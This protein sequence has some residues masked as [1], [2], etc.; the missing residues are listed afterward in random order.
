V[1]CQQIIN[2]K[3]ITTTFWL[4]T[5]LWIYIL[6]T[7]THDMSVIIHFIFLFLIIK[8]NKKSQKIKM[9]EKPNTCSIIHHPF[10][11]LLLL[12]QIFTF[13]LSIH[14]LSSNSFWVLLQFF[15]RFQLYKNLCKCCSKCGS[16]KSY[17]FYQE[18]KDIFFLI[19]FRFRLFHFFLCH[20][21]K[22]KGEVAF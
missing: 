15:K 7:C 4:Q 10:H 20:W 14:L 8:K 22:F 16:C 19:F 12:T 17:W 5:D 3:V 21:K 6:I 9:L 11:I 2:K 18:K 13:S 1:L